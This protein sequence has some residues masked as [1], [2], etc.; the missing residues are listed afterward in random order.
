MKQTVGGVV[1][2]AVRLEKWQ[3][4]GSLKHW[5]TEKAGKDRQTAAVVEALEKALEKCVCY[6]EED[7]ML[8][9]I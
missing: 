3:H 9:N 8:Q 7:A 4:E 1:K 5:T 2:Q 6:S